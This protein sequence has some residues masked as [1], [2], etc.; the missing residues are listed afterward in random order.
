MKFTVKN[1]TTLDVTVEYEDGTTAVFPVTKSMT[2]DDIKI[3]AN[4]WNNTQVPYDNVDAV[5]VVVDT[6]Y[7]VIEP[8]TD[9]TVDFRVARRANYPTLGN[10]LDALY[11]ERQGDDTNRKIVDAQIKA[12][13]D[14]I[15]KDST[16][17]QSEIDALFDTG[18]ER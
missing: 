10:Q 3:A 2:L 8:E 18:G 6:E 5:P 14:G 17:K 12:V 9:P 4:Q 11:W 15:S 16:Y 7:E 13:K 1:K